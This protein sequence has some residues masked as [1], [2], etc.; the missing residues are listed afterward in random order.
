MNKKNKRIKRQ[1]PALPEITTEYLKIMDNLN[2]GVSII[3]DDGCF[4]FCNKKLVNMLGYSEKQLL[5]ESVEK[6]LS[7]NYKNIF[8]KNLKRVLEKKQQLMNIRCGQLMVN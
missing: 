6:I 8:R 1:R 5:N 4:A 2:D 7:I 3:R